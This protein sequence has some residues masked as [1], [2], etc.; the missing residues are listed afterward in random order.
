MPHRDALSAA[1]HL[2]C[3]RGPDRGIVIA[4]RTQVIIGRRG[5]IALADPSTPRYAARVSPSRHR[6]NPRVRV[7]DMRTEKT[8]TLRPG[9]RLQVGS[10]IWELR[11]RPTDLRWPLP[12]PSRTPM[13]WMRLSPLIF[14]VF[15]LSRWMPVRLHYLVAALVSVVMV[16]LS[17]WLTRYLVR[18]SRYDPALLS[19]AVHT[20]QNHPRVTTPVRVWLYAVGGRSVEVSARHSIAC[21]GPDAEVHARWIAAQ[22][23]IASGL[24]LSGSQC[25]AAD[26]S[27]WLCGNETDADAPEGTY[28]V[29]WGHT[30]EQVPQECLQIVNS[31][32]IAASGWM[33]IS[34]KSEE[35]PSLVTW[36]QLGIDCSIPATA[37]RWQTRKRIL[38]VPVGAHER[39]TVTIDLPGDG[40]HGLVAGSTGSGKSEALRTWICSLALHNSPSDLQ[41]VLIDYKGGAG[42]GPLQRLPH[43]VEFHTDLEAPMTAWLLRRLGRVMTDRKE[44]LHNAGFT[45]IYQWECSRLDAP[46][47]IV[48]VI[49]EF[50]ALG[51][52]HPEFLPALGRLAAQGR[53]LGIH[54]IVSTQ[55]P[56]PVV[57]ATLKANLDI[58][59]ALRCTEDADSQAVLGNA[60]AAAL[61]RVP[62]RGLIGSTLVQFA[63]GPIPCFPRVPTPASPFPPLLPQSTRATFG[64]SAL[65]CTLPPPRT[66]LLIAAPAGRSAELGLWARGIG[67]A[68]ADYVNLPLVIANA[69]LGPALLGHILC[70]SLKGNRVMVF[71]EVGP[72]LR[73]LES[74]GAALEAGRMWAQILSSAGERGNHIIV[75]DSEGHPTSGRIATRLL[76]IPSLSAW[77]DPLMARIVPS[78]PTFRDA[79]PDCELVREEA[80]SSLAGRFLA[81]NYVD[82]LPLTMVQLGDDLMK[83]VANPLDLPHP[84]VIDHADAV[85]GNSGLADTWECTH[86]LPHQFFQALTAGHTSVYFSQPSLDVVR[87]LAQRYPADSLWLRASY[88]YLEDTGVMAVKDAVTWATHRHCDTHHSS[89]MRVRSQ[90]S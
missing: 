35:I 23:S 11:H 86:Y 24:P 9:N 32:P 46:P 47:R 30:A 38:E 55:H 49:D 34:D 60:A 65:G 13:K 29:A 1:L 51:E 37:A 5:S 17:L 67:A 62:G 22:L 50:Q 12:S 33:H 89:H 15:A 82:S 36:D 61:P 83:A 69:A 56:G 3:V 64:V 43:V 81:M 16:A 40:P 18:R 78:M 54:L 52:D 76:Q 85:V 57:T 42:L 79:S 68:V 6:G 72:I 10:D 73:E 2:A 70:E 77:Q 14:I 88:P 84:V 90:N 59:V 28:V 26:P 48:V 39:G 58:R 8:V 31:R 71:E 20:R 75:T 25:P 53:S 66:P 27:V 41:L 63:Y 19:L 45:D 80:I 21:V 7:L 44:H 4:L 74:Q 87:H